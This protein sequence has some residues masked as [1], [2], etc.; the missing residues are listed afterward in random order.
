MA[1]NTNPIFIGTPFLWVNIAK[2]ITCTRDGT[3]GVPTL[4][5]TAGTYGSFIETIYAV[6]LGDNV[7]STLRLYASPS[8]QTGI[9][10][11]LSET[12]LPVVTGSN[13]TTAQANITV[14]LPAI[15]PSGNGIRLAPSMKLY[16]ALGT[17]VASGYNIFVGGGDY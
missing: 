16:C 9:Y 7:V 15:Q 2:S 5:G 12:N 14:T 3:S 4:L 6:P 13:N 10:Y 17:P 8:G 1:T 11:L